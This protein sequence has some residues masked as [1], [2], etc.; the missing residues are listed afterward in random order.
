VTYRVRR[1]VDVEE[2][3]LALAVWMARD[4][5]ES[6]VRFFAAVEDSILSLRSMPNPGSPK[7]LRSRRLAGV[8]SLAVAGFPRHLVL[9]EVR[10]RDVFVLPVVHGARNYRKLLTDRT[11]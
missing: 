5:R 2:D 1:H 6:A 11:R 4:S 8:R 10:V 7:R 3:I 9:Y